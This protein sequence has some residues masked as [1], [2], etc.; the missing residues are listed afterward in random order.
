MITVKRTTSDDEDFNYLTHLFD[1]YLVEIDGAEK[2]FF[3]QFNHVYLKNVV[4]LYENEVAL[5]CG[6]FKEY[7]PDVAEIKRMFVLPEARGKGIASK[8]LSE[9][10]LWITE[11][12]YTTCVLETSIRLEKAITL[13]KKFGFVKTENYGQYIGV[14]SSVCMKKNL[15][16][17]IKNL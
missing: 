16:S 7:E 4:V 1:E 8:I 17:E 13:Y 15:N 11:E 5:G 14:K 10:E 9:L 12:N 3:A 6:A 2:D